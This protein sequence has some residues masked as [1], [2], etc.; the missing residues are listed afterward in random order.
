MKRF[1]WM[2]AGLLFLAGCDSG[3]DVRGRRRRAGHSARRRRRVPGRR[4]Q[5]PDGRG[6]L[7]GG[8]GLPPQLTGAT[9]APAC[10]TAAR[11][12]PAPPASTPTTARRG[13]VCA[14]GPLPQALL[15]RRL[16]GLRQP[17]RALHPAA[18]LPV[19]IE[20]RRD[21]RHALLP[22]QHLR[23]A[24]ALELHRGGHELS[25]RRPDRRHRLPHRGHRRGGRSLPVQGRLLL[26]RAARQGPDVRASVQRQGRR[27]ALRPA[28]PARAPARTTRAIRPA[29][30]SASRPRPPDGPRYLGFALK[31]AKARRTPSSV[32]TSG[33]QPRR[34]SLALSKRLPSSSW[35]SC[36]G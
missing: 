29:S 27:A 20:R 11:P 8:A 22:D 30:A 24:L 31:S 19:G 28:R 13:H 3:G 17:H 9:A 5:L 35:R 18:R 2:A 10:N 23:R 33:F 14:G 6:L 21:R 16:D 36:R 32:E 34:F 15:R 7:G 12:R 1:G 4:L 25:D 26:R